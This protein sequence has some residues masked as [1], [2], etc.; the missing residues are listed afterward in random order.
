MLNKNLTFIRKLF[1]EQK[2][3]YFSLNESLI[4]SSHVPASMPAKYDRK[5]LSINIDFHALVWTSDHISTAGD[6]VYAIEH[7][8]A[9]HL[10]SS[11]P[12]PTDTSLR[13]YLSSIVASRRTWVSPPSF[14]YSG[15]EYNVKVYD[16][17]HRA[18]LW[19]PTEFAVHYE[20]DYNHETFK[21]LRRDCGRR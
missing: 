3:L 20:S 13:A 10:P 12:L 1:T 6:G 19:F 16:G 4:Q 8:P 15:M 5:P 11:H 7:A 21:K 17:T 14:S 18:G 9:L 2:W